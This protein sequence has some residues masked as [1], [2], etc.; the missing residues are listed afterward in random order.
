MKNKLL[1][2]QIKCSMQT[3]EMSIQTIC[4]K[5]ILIFKNGRARYLAFSG[6][7]KKKKLLY[8][9]SSKQTI[10]KRT[11]MICAKKILIYKNVRFSYITF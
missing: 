11:Q 2:T 6:I 9:R 3:I 5:K 7:K 8:I 10:H 1:K 4:I